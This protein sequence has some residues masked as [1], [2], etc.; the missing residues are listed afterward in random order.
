MMAGG[1]NSANSGG[2]EVSSDVGAGNASGQSGEVGAEGW[3][4]GASSEGW[5]PVGSDASSESWSPAEGD[6]GALRHFPEIASDGGIETLAGPEQ[7]SDAHIEQAG[8]Q[9]HLE[10]PAQ[11]GEAGAEHWRSDFQAFAETVALEAHET[12]GDKPSDTDVKA[13]ELM[14]DASDYMNDPEN[15]E[16]VG[17]LHARRAE[18]LQEANP[19]PFRPFESSED[20]KELLE[21]WLRSEAEWEQMSP[22]EKAEWERN[23]WDRAERELEAFSKISD[24]E[25]ENLILR[26]SPKDAKE[27]EDFLR[28]QM[29]G[30]FAERMAANARHW[31]S[32]EGGREKLEQTVRRAGVMAIST[33]EDAVNA[34]FGNRGDNRSR[35]RHLD[36]ERDAELRRSEAERRAAEWERRSREGRD[37]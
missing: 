3:G 29:E 28:A 30:G 36:A 9:Q 12:V 23:F 21:S 1:E 35:E 24:H 27:T 6:A 10:N 22:T 15:E 31:W 34:A 7:G 2:G 19:S 8:E 20:G 33:Y 14:K 25:Y 37:R 32:Q 13:N 17:A 4:S 5:G 18:A 16:A 11:Q 26:R